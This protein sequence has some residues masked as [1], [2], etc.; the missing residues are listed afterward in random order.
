MGD[1]IEKI[2]ELSLNHDSLRGRTY[3]SPAGKNRMQ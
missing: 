3:W 1:L 2:D